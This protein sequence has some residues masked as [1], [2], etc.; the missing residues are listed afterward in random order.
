MDVVGL[1]API[2][3]PDMKEIAEDEQQLAARAIEGVE[4]GGE[5]LAVAARPPDVRIGEQRDG[6]AASLSDRGRDRAGSRLALV[7]ANAAEVDS[8]SAIR[9]RPWRQRPGTHLKVRPGLYSQMEAV[10]TRPDF[11]RLEH[12]ILDFWRD[13]GRLRQAAADD[14]RP[15]ALPLHR[16]PDHRQQSDGRPS[17]LGP[18]AQGRLHPLQGDARPHLPLP[19]R[20]RLPGPLG[21]GRGREGAPV[22]RQARHRGVRHRPLLRGVQGPR[23]EVREGHHRPVDPARPVDGL[24]EQ[25]LHAP[26]RE[27][28]RDLALPQGV[29]GARLA[30]RQ[31]PQ[32]AVVPALRHQPVRARDG[33]LAPGR[34]APRRSS[35]TSPSS[36][37]ARATC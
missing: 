14:R 5:V 28:P 34:R 37:T 21:R 24:G 13:D 35:R 22:Q 17:R 20:L 16:R 10:P 19:E 6:H 7:A 1:V 15:A 4:L 30:L 26:R 8:L 12:D 2:A 9:A 25:L 29:R 36:R 11:V 33:R 31:G 23:R 32:H 18:H 27:H 3:D